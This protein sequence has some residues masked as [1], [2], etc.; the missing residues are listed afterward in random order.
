MYIHIGNYSLNFDGITYGKGA[1]VLKQLVARVGM[2]N[3][4]KGMWYDLSILDDLWYCM[5]LYVD[6]HAW[7][8][9]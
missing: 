6:V 2:L 5:Y 1:S 7:L 3:F 9:Y 4:K 8:D